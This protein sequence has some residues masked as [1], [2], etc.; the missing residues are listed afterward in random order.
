MLENPILLLRLSVQFNNVVVFLYYTIITT[1]VHWNSNRLLLAVSWNSVGACRAFP[2]DYGC[3]FALSPLKVCWTFQSDQKCL[4][5][6]WKIIGKILWWKNK[7]ICILLTLS[8]MESVKCIAR[9]WTWKCETRETRIKC[10][11]KNPKTPNTHS[12]TLH[13]HYHNLGARV[14]GLWYWKISLVS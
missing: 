3:W 1:I 6:H 10:L 4:D 12:H 8:L 7:K 11:R 2:V 5:K 9:G 14:R 13:T